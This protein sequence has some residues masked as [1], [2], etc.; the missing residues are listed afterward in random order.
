M[1]ANLELQRIEFFRLPIEL[2]LVVL[3]LLC[4]TCFD[5]EGVQSKLSSNAEERQSQIATARKNMLEEKKKLRD[6]SA[7]KRNEAIERC[8]EINQKA[9]EQTAGSK[10]KGSK[11]DDKT[12]VQKKLNFK[13]AASSDNVAASADGADGD[14]TD[15]NAKVVK[16]K[17]PFDPS[18]AQL[19]AMLEEMVKLDSMGIDVVLAAPLELDPLSDD[20]DPEME[21]TRQLIA[22]LSGPLSRSQSKG[23]REK[24][25][26]RDKRRAERNAVLQA[27]QIMP[28]LISSAVQ[29]KRERDIKEAIRVG[30][31]CGYVGQLSGKEKKVFC[32]EDMKK[33]ND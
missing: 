19:A 33:V 3:K 20:E 2:K 12:S 17:N 28:S 27:R 26:E 22:S 10:G 4:Q 9:A 15:G 18:P 1:E 13:S 25:K 14:N 32:T 8:R 29:S 7:L 11:A 21:S 16:E 31:T 23:S 5:C 6:V 30:K 24:D